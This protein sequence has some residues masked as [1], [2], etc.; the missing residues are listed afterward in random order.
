MIGICRVILEECIH[1]TAKEIEVWFIDAVDRKDVPAI[2][3]DS[4]DV[5]G[6]DTHL[7][8]R[9]L[10]GRQSP[11]RDIG[12]CQDAAVDIDNLEGFGRSFRGGGNLS[13][14]FS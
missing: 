2:V 8:G 4:H 13:A 6:R 7:T 12:V 14:D 3:H 9:R 10:P 1:A 5:G 11:L